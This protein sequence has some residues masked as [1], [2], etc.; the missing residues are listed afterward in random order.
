[1]TALNVRH[2]G[3]VTNDLKSQLIFTK[4]LGFK[5]CKQMNETDPSL[6]NL[7]SLKVKVKQLR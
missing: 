3:I 4:D 7:M 5:N 6:S 2:V 1:M